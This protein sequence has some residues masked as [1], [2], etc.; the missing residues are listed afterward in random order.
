MAR[1]KIVLEN[2]EKIICDAFYVIKSGRTIMT[3]CKEL[4]NKSVP[5]NTI[6]YV[7]P[8]DDEEENN[9]WILSS[10]FIFDSSFIYYILPIQK[11]GGVIW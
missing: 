3:N 1:L 11:F 8:L 7:I 4:T 10:F 2:E 9:E 6:V 5:T